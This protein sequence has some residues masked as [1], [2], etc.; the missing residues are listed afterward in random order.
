MSS[1]QST[2]WYAIRVKSNCERVANEAL[3]GR[4]IETCLPLYREERSGRRG[5][6][7][8]IVELPLFAGYLFGRFDARNRL[9]VLTVPGVVHVV[10]FGNTPQPLDTDEVETLMTVLA[11]PLRRIP[12]PYLPVGQTVQIEAGP[13]RGL[14]G[15]IV[16]DKGGDKLVVSISLLQRS[17][18]VDVDRNWVSPVPPAQ[19]AR[20][21]CNHQPFGI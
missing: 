3:L 17:V 19:Q 8:R 12:F 7:K 10:S 9:P 20:R 4:G 1:Q 14:E 15:I 13:L 6:D 21:S 18:A 11:S 5:E 2:N 16:A